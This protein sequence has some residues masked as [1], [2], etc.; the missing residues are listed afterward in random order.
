MAYD[1]HWNAG[2]DFLDQP[3]VLLQRVTVGAESRIPALAAQVGSEHP[4]I[5]GQP[6]H[7]RDPLPGRAGARVQAKE[8]FSLA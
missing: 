3:D 7:Q 4:K 5:P 2:G 1:V 6:I 8:R